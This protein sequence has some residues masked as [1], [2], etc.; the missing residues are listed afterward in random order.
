MVIINVTHN[1]LADHDGTYHHPKST[2]VF[3]WDT[4]E[5]KLR[6]HSL[7]NNRPA[8]HSLRDGKFESAAKSGRGHTAQ[9][10]HVLELGGLSCH[11]QYQDIF[12]TW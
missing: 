9:A 10:I 1:N 8:T 4:R 11:R 12:G 3:Q 5:G 6:S 2:T 7:Y